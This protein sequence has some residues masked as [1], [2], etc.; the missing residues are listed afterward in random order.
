MRKINKSKNKVEIVSISSEYSIIKTFMLF[1]QLAGVTIKYIDS[2]FYRTHHLSMIKYITLKVL[3]VNGGIMKHSELAR[4]TNTKK[5]NITTL[6]ERMKR[7]RLVTTERSEKDR[8]I[9]NIILTD[10]GQKV[11]EKANVEAIKMVQYLM[12]GI[13]ENDAREFER[14]LNIIKGNVERS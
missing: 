4:W 9:I 14:L 1:T 10:K 5:H 3:V 6:I 8:R 12:T 11:Y 7:Q 2:Q 13:D